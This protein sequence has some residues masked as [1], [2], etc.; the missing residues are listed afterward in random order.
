VSP[1]KPDKRAQLNS[2]VI[3][4]RARLKGFST[5]GLAP[6]QAADTTIGLQQAIIRAEDE[7][8]EWVKAE[9]IA[10][11]RKWSAVEEPS[12]LGLRD[13]LLSRIIQSL[14]TACEAWLSYE[15]VIASV[16]EGRR[17]VQD[18]RRAYERLP[19]MATRWPERQTALLPFK[20]NAT[21]YPGENMRQVIA[22]YMSLAWPGGNRPRAVSV[23]QFVGRA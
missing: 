23:D 15:G 8:A 12:L 5:A 11:M 10:D 1:P 13:E 22:H 6:A 20:G 14:E 18:T 21:P 19:D 9:R 7:L 3:E 17:I 2:A 16:K 4:A